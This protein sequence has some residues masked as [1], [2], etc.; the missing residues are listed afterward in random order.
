MSS[1]VFIKN[2][3]PNKFTENDF[4]SHFEKFA[5]I[6]DIK[7]IPNRRIGYVGF[8]S[9]EDAERAVKYFNKT[10]IRMSRIAVEIARPIADFSLPR[11][12]SAH[13][14]GS[15]AY[16][17]KHEQKPITEE[18]VT[19]RKR[20]WGETD[21]LNPAMD[22]KLLEY[23]EV[24]QPSSKARTWSNGDVAAPDEESVKPIQADENESDDEYV[25]IPRRLN[26]VAAVEG[27]TGS[28][29]VMTE[30]PTEQGRDH[31]QVKKTEKN[32]NPSMDDNEWLLS[33][34]SRLLDLTDDIEAH[35]AHLTTDVEKSSLAVRPTNKATPPNSIM[36]ADEGQEDHEPQEKSEED[37]VLEEIGKT[38][39]L[40]LRNLP[41]TTTEEELWIAFELFG[42]LEEAHLALDSKT[43]QSKGFAF[44][45]FKSPADAVA[46]YK[47]MDK[48]IFQGRLLHIIAGAPKRE[49]KLDEFTISKL[50]LKKQLELKRKGQS[51][52]WNSMYMNVDAVM[53]SIADRLG[54]PKSELLDPTSSDAAVKQAH[55]ETQVILETKAYLKE[56]GVD[57]EAFGKNPKYREKDDRVILLKNFPYGT[58]KEE[59]LK[60][61]GEFGQV[62]R[63]L[64]PPAGTMAITEFVQAPA[65]L[66]AY[67]SL[68]YRRFKNMPLFLEKAPKG[69]LGEAPAQNT[70][71]IVADTSAGAGAGAS[72]GK[73]PKLSIQEL[74]QPSTVDETENIDTTTL[75]VRNLNFS[76]TSADLTRAFSAID[77]FRKAVVKTKPDPKKPG[78]TLSMGFGFVEFQSKAQAHTAIQ[79][80]NGY[81]LDGHQLSVKTSHRGL[82]AAAEQKKA[83][84]A[85]KLAANKTKLVIKN[86][87]FEAS[88]KDVRR[89]VAPYGKLRALRLPKKF[90]SRSSGF[91][92]AEFVSAKEAAMAMSSLTD[93]HFLGRKLVLEYSSQDA[94]TAEEEIEKM[95]KKT[96]KQSQLAVMQSLREANKRRKF[97]INAGR[98]DEL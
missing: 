43:N 21:E 1:R 61:L 74:L 52:N 2:L 24:M 8:K 60:I 55:A 63:F 73:A 98:E 3:P 79:V 51:F 31:A 97:D 70:E 64:M 65:A 18:S 17:R 89:L 80:M 66:A 84:L 16:Q 19:A 56:S 41:Y 83:D 85:K 71:T 47:E 9:A 44:V 33:K 23:L 88:E 67:K 4:R 25:E 81:T 20:K 12:W 28:E 57:F 77:G 92:F 39:R 82:D 76:T 26:S 10:F 91:A 6:T 14:P 93:T 68:A 78:A 46:A 36:K 69:L 72:G 42:E 95:Q 5:P 37:A 27:V 86:L 58:T 29:A 87:P 15:S 94:I 38:G 35:L 34:T 54:V 96:G 48:K 13:T 49:N 62:S 7:L 11:P 45:L 53:S 75:Y 50:P 90:G 22:P 59:L 30:P 32:N 40:F